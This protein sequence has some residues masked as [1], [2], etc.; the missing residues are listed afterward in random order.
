ML[1]FS[2]LPRR[3]RKRIGLSAAQKI[4]CF[5]RL[6]V[7]ILGTIILFHR[8]GSIYFAQKAWKNAP[9][10]NMERKC[11][12]P[13]YPT[14]SNSP[15]EAGKICLTTLTD[16]KDKAWKTRYFGWR[17]L[18][19][20]LELTWQ[21][22]QD[23]ANKHGYF[24]FN[25]SAIMDTGRPPAWSKIKATKRLLREESCDWVYW[26]DA[27]TVFMN[28]DKRVEDFLPS[29]PTKHFLVAPDKG[30]GYNSGAWIIRNSP[31]SLQFLDV[32]WNQKSFIRLP[33]LSQ[34][35]DN[36]SLKYLLGGSFE[37]APKEFA[38]FRNHILSPA[39]CTFNSFAKF[40]T[41]SQYDYVVENLQEQDWYLSE[42]WYHKGDLLAHVAGF[43]NKIET[44]K[45][46]LAKAK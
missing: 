26:V 27:D 1:A 36:H 39:R 18:D 30:G 23:Y 40:L 32:W 33:G 13:P 41:P 28:S 10:V 45:L 14:M 22:K 37:D 43:D 5:G 44:L 9:I 31:W 2:L 35:G 4:G 25:E 11:P 21:N 19:G 46:L 38:S 12:H 6:F 7:M 17:N 20:I 34:S 8:L 29:D 15:K 42:G 24:L 3:R 16:E